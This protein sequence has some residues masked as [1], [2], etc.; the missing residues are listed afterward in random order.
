VSSV[1]R[2]RRFLLALVL[3]GAVG[4]VVELLLLGHYDSPWKLAPL[5]I[6]LPTLVASVAVWVQP[7]PATIRFF[8]ATMVL[9]VVTGL[10]GLILHY[11]GNL[12]FALERDP[13]LAGFT[14]LLKGLRGATP[15]LAPGALA[16]LGLLGLV[17]AYRHPALDRAHTTD[18]ETI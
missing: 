15:S 16:Q 4:L 1:A 8:R 5:I 13:S 9:C 3:F 7:S 6:L 17:F 11:K 14:L 2:L 12:E 18:Q 10:L